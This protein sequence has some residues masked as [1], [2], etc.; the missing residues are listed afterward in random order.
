MRK[1]DRKRNRFG[2]TNR[3][4]RWSAKDSIA[5]KIPTAETIKEA[6]N[7]IAKARNKAI[8]EIATPHKTD[9]LAIIDEV[10]KYG[11]LKNGPKQK[12]FMKF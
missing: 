1:I 9:A 3:R 7:Y 8:Q 6:G 2:K 10:V 4:A 5:K 11:H 12:R